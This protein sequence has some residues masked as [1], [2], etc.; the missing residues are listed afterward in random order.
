[1]GMARLIEPKAASTVHVCEVDE[2]EP[3]FFLDIVGL[4]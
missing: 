3:A 1:M 2:D 4:V